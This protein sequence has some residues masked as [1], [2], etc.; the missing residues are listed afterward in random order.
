MID[1]AGGLYTI[2]EF[3][4]LAGVSA[5]TLRHYDRVGVLRPAV[6]D[7]RTRYRRYSG[8]QLAV[9]H[10]VLSLTNLGLS[11]RQVR[12]ALGCS[13]A[14][15]NALLAA[16]RAIASRVA[17][18]TARLEWIEARLAGMDRGRREND[19]VV[20]LKRQPSLAVVAVRD[21]LGS[22]D[23]A[24]A[25]LD[26]LTSDPVGLRGTLWHD[27][28]T[29]TGIIDCEAV[30]PAHA[31][32]RRHRRASRGRVRELP[33]ATFACTVH[34]GD[35]GSLSAYRALHRWI[36][37]HGYAVDGP[38]REWYLGDLDGI[39]VTEIQIPVAM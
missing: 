5:K 39:P 32:A 17:A 7:D 3:A 16:K 14:V 24:D 22:Y 20:V 26:R 31:R 18:D 21:R 11:L 35:E 4:R 1:R 36:D 37:A 13:I 28:G 30:I 25:L 38:N 10:E 15:G 8:D 19:P 27:C 34:Q 29:H 12:E 33:A 23:E 2:G 9:L 6:V